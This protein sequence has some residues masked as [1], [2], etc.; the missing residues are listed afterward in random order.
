MER[1]KEGLSDCCSAG[2]RSVVHEHQADK[3]QVDQGGIEAAVKPK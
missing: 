2:L 3:V 1:E